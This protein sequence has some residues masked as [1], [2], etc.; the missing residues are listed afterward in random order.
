MSLSATFNTARSSLQATS[1]R[2]SVSASNVASADDTSTS[3]KIAVV[4]TTSDGGSKVVNITRASD[5]ALYDRMLSA[6]SSSS[7]L[8]AIDSGLTVLQQ[9]VG[10]TESETSPAALLG[11]FSSA[12][13]SAANAPDD[14][15]LAA[16]AVTAAQNVAQSLND[17]SETVQKVRTDADSSIATSVSNV[18]DLLAK[19]QAA[20][21]AVVQGT[22]I[23]AN[24]TDALDRRDAILSDLS[25]EMGISTLTRANNDVAI[26]TDSGVTL[27]DKSARSVTF[28]ASGALD[29]TSSGNAV[30]VDGVAVAGPGASSSMT[31]KSGAIAGYAELR[32][33]VAVT[34]QTQLDEVARGLITAFAETDQTGGTTTLAG[35]F[36]AGSGDTSVPSSLVAGL[37]GNITVN[38]AADSTQGGS[39]FTLRDGGMNGASYVYNADSEA[40]YSTRLTELIGAL[41]ASQTYDSSSQLESDTSVMTF[42]TASVSW[43]QGQR[44]VVSTS[45]DTQ[46]AVLSQTSTALSSATGVNLDDEY[47]LQLELERSYQASSKL[48]GVVSDLYDQLFSVI[49]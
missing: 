45:L 19:F 38:A 7:K 14:S 8:S 2:L 24:V 23:G 30:Y 39:P 44:S 48:I 13:S 6:T 32:D 41:S 20:N 22:A 42:A 46:S 40:S 5:S 43:L 26:Y 27:F 47:A 15:A 25:E 3:R 17:A 1:T 11:V 4:T 16:S 34:Y 37:A 12:L 35:L 18:N 36:T 49:G 29:A 10:D 28:Q 21:D 9:T 31:L 33:D